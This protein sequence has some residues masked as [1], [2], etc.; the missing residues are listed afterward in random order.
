MG[1]SPCGTSTCTRPS[2]STT[3]GR[4][5]QRDSERRSARRMTC[6]ASRFRRRRGWPPRTHERATSAKSSRS[7]P[8]GLWNTR[9]LLLRRPRTWRRSN[10]LVANSVRSGLGERLDPVL[11]VQTHGSAAPVGPDRWHP[12][13]TERRQPAVRRTAV[14]RRQSGPAAAAATSSAGDRLAGR[15]GAFRSA[16]PSKPLSRTLGPFA[17]AVSCRPGWGSGA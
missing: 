9:L 11:H 3:W 4:Q 8:R 14:G 13:T 15:H 16:S 1:R 10:W 7:S 12:E 5:R 17:V 6:T 2:R